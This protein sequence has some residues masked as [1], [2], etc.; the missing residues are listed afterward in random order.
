VGLPADDYADNGF[1]PYRLYVRE[2]RRILDDY[3][4][5]EADI[6][7]YLEGRGLIQPVK[8]DSIAA[9]HYALDSKPFYRKTNV[10][11][12][13]KGDGNFYI[14]S[15]MPYQV[16]YRSIIPRN[17]EG[18]LVP[19]AISAT[20]VAFSA[21]RMDPTWMVMGQAAD[22]AAALAVKQHVTVRQVP[23]DMIQRELL[24]QR[25]W[26]MFYWDLPRDH[27]AFPAIEWLSV[28]KVVNGY[29][30]RLFRPDRNLTRAEM[31]A[32]LVRAFDVWP[33]VSNQH[34]KDVPYLDW[35]YRDIGSLYDNGV[36]QA[37][38]I[39]PLWPKSGSWDDQATH[40]AGYWQ[41]SGSRQFLPGKEASWREFAGAI[42]I[43]QTRGIASPA[44]DGGAAVVAAVPD[45]VAWAKTEFSH[46]TFG[47]G[48]AGR[49]FGPDSPVTRG[50]AC[51]L[52]A[53]LMDQTPGMR[54]VTP[55]N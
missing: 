34:F 15:T 12:P 44:Q 3:V 48:Y 50:A 4:M 26:I 22:I 30:D 24:K 2:A 10:A 45:P 43:L 38:G 54:A 49:Q 25:C 42:Q 28:R 11:T 33:S 29:P 41:D 27:A 23:V 14:S 35:A 55:A 20:H 18:L 6:N 1:V 21:I 8:E 19:T 17:V 7:A 5:S 47:T 37:F 39:E 9:G 51:A 16:P 52:I 36:L 13:D 46:S 53:A 32:L 31:A 40:N